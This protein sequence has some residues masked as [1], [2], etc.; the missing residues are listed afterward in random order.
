MLIFA[1]F[2]GLN[3]FL[4]VFSLYL[5]AINVQYKN[6]VHLSAMISFVKHNDD[7]RFRLKETTVKRCLKPSVP[8]SVSKDDPVFACE[9]VAL[10][11]WAPLS[12]AY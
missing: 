9:L 8:D 4:S 1:L 11:I 12:V 6:T 2:L 3:L 5:S 10:I 7:S